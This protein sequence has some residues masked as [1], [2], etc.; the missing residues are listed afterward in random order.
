MDR[1][2]LQNAN[3]YYDTFVSCDSRQ[4]HYIITMMNRVYRVIAIVC[5]LAFL[6]SAPPVFA[7]SVSFNISGDI[8][9]IC[10]VENVNVD[11]VEM[12]D[13]TPGTS[14]TL[15]EVK[16]KCTLPWGFTRKI[17]SYNGGALKFANQTIPY[18]LSH[19]G[20]SYLGLPFTDATL[21]S[22]IVTSHASVFFVLGPKG[23]LSV[24]FPT[25]PDDLLA[26]TYTD[27]I[28]VTVTSN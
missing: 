2:I 7:N 21:S 22:P 14:Q 10:G 11:S 23:E 28:I 27:T 4:K 20:S 13:L 18:T 17:E 3:K 8:P 16:Y 15:G 6:W 25:I 12:L 26:G 19:T 1:G 5:I 24:K 9:G